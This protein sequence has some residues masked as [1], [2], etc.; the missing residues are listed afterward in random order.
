MRL[1]F[2]IDGVFLGVT[3]ID[4][5]SKST[6]QPGSYYN[7]A[8]KQGGEVGSVSA[9]KDIFDMFVA[10]QVKEFSGCRFDCVFDDRFA[11]L[12]VVGIH[13]QK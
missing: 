7:V 9:T 5:I 12:Q 3:K 8:V 4:Y 1:A 2:N 11:R 10:G 13:P 6:G